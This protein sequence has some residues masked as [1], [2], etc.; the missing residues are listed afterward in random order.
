[1]K[2]VVLAW[3]FFLL[4]GL[5]IGIVVPLGEGFDEPWHLGYVQYLSQTGTLPPGPG[6]HLSVELETFLRL[7]PVGWR[8]K[9]IY[10]GLLSQEDYWHASESDRTR[11]D[12]T[13]RD[14]QF[15]AIY[16]EGDADF[17]PQY[18][19]HQ[20]PLYYMLMAPL[21]FAGSRILSFL[22]TF[23]LLRFA[24]LL[25]AS[26]VV[27]L[28]FALAKHVSASHL[29]P[30]S[31]VMI[32]ALFPGIYPD[33][34]RVSNDA[35]AVPLAAATFV[36]LARYLD[37]DSR[38]D[39]LLLGLTLLA[40]LSTKAFFVP[41]VVAI[42]AWMVAARRFP[43]AMIVSGM[44]IPGWIWYLR[45]LLVTGSVTGLPETVAANATMTSS[46]TSLAAID[47]KGL[48]RLAA[49]SHIWIGN[50][51][52]L[53]Y[54]SWIYQTI[55]VLFVAGAVGFLGC[56]FRSP[57]RILQ[58]LVLIYAAFAASLV[59][60][61]T[62][63]LQQIGVP[64]I[65]GW[66]LSLMIPIEAIAFAL[67]I[68][69]LFRRFALGITAFTGV[70]FLAMLI[71]GN[72]FI[73]APYYAGLID[74]AASGHLQAYHPHWVDVPVLAARLIRFHPWIPGKALILAAAGVLV[75]GFSLIWQYCESSR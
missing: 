30:K 38:K 34:V 41:I 70:C 68:E 31:A 64:V 54:R 50:W 44:S 43:A 13:L 74:H 26:A 63:V 5:F 8:L 47:W 61:A 24:S 52:L 17:S 10:P 9:G 36:M 27:P 59:Y 72:V 42:V 22:D 40:G 28:T 49:V 14:L 46:I 1:M 23:L 18:E 60:Y 12:E 4:T 39:R 57:S 6:L 20:A 55:L 45:N 53:Q 66:Y 15:G 73:A 65:Q 75:A 58:V 67:G 48:L 11:T 25:M 2:V 35:L 37:S 32:V 33:V 62:Q 56:F 21:F 29:P 7:H 71:Y 3:L 51:S 16:K 69:F 19:S